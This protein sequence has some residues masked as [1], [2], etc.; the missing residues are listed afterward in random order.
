MN[1]LGRLTTPNN[2]TFIFYSA[3]D[4][5]RL[6]PQQPHKVFCHFSLAPILSL[7]CAVCI[8]LVQW[9]GYCWNRALIFEVS[10][11]MKDNK[12]ELAKCR[13]RNGAVPRV[14]KIRL[15]TKVF[16]SVVKTSFELRN[17]FVMILLT[18]FGAMN[19]FSANHRLL[20]M[21]FFFFSFFFLNVHLG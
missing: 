8:V 9:K 18:F 11:C 14:R 10:M 7:L 13:R 1:S 15:F 17:I 2:I 20:L 19:N 5:R 4:L 16:H 3:M 6:Q 12:S 21:I